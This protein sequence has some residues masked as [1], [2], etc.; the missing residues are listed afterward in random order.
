M[1]APLASGVFSEK[2][3]TIGNDGDNLKREPF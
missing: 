3:F 1:E 2:T